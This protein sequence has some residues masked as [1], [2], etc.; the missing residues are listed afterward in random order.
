M[1]SRFA[2]PLG[3][4]AS[5]FGSGWACRAGMAL[6]R[7]SADAGVV[8]IVL[9]QVEWRRIAGDASDDVSLVEATVGGKQDLFEVT[10]LGGGGRAQR[11]LGLTG[12]K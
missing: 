8:A 10:Q 5:V 3:R 1:Y 12:Q 9:L 4:V 7:S 11:H 2:P 6:S